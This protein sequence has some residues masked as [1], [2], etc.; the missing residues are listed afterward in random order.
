[1]EITLEKIEL[2]KDRT[3]VSYKEAK[4]ALESTDGSVV[5]A[6]IAIEEAVDEKPGKK[7]NAAAGET[8]EKIKELVKKG[9]ITRITI[10]RD[11]EVLLNLPLNAGIVG[12]IV[13]PWGVIAGVIAAFGFKCRIELTKDDGTVIDISQR[14]EAIGKEVAEKGSVVVDD[15]VAKGSEAYNNIKDAASD[16]ITE[17]RSKKEEAFDDIEEAADALGD[18][19]EDLLGKA[20]AKAGKSCEEEPEKEEDGDADEDAPEA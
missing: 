6:I 10:S 1:M 14:A 4:D 12:A 18:K 2:V 9:N 5:D 20:E 19:F 17:F 16:K 7:V 15:V 11:G 8:V 13:A 3:G